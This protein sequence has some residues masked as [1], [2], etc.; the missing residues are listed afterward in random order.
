MSDTIYPQ[1]VQPKG[2]GYKSENIKAYSHYREPIDD[3]PNRLAGNSRIWGD[4]S[5]QVQSRVV[6]ILIE[7]A[8]EKGLSTRET[9][10][11]LAIAR[12]ESGFN[13][14]AA[15]GTT[16]ASGLGQFIDGTGRSYGLGNN[17]FDAQDG[18]RALVD[19]FIDN[20]KLASARGQGE[21]YIYK[22]HHDGPT[23]DYGGLDLAKDKVL[24]FVDK[25][26]KLL[27]QQQLG[28]PLAP[29]QTTGVSAT[30]TQT[31]RTSFDATMQ[32]MMP[33]QAG[34][35][36]HITGSYGEDR[37]SKNHGGVDFNY[38]GG[39]TGRNLQ[40]PV[41]N[42]PVSGKVTFSGGAY[43]TVKI[44]DAQGNSHEILH[45]H[46]RNVK[47]GDTVQAG[48]PIGTMGGRGPDGPNQYAQ[49]VH[50]QLRNPAGSIIDP[51]SFWNGRQITTGGNNP[52]AIDTRTLQEKL[53]A[54]G[55]TGTQGQALQADGIAGS[56]TN[57]AL[58]AFQK[59]HGL[60]VDGIAGPAT[61]GALAGQK[62]LPQQGNAGPAVQS[63][64]EQLNQLG[65]TDGRGRALATDG[66]FGNNTEQ[67][68]EAFQKA[69]GLK[70]DGV[71]GPLTRQALES[72]L[73]KA[74]QQA[75]PAPAASLQDMP[76]FQKLKGCMPDGLSLEKIGQATTCA[77]KAGIDSAEKVQQV[78]VN[79]SM[80][81]VIGTTAGFRASVDL[82]ANP[83]S[84]E[85]SNQQ[86]LALNQEREQQRSQSQAVTLSA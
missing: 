62:S 50:Y 1:M 36:P 74:P 45:L 66:K 42:A 61:L 49:H 14:D 20:R 57:H 28:A 23:R 71:A 21:A 86:L 82:A 4:A 3:A 44:L 8:R 35:K 48:K 9:A 10:H 13:P 76:L 75:T 16:S 54:L 56:H 72:A 15:A 43:G 2:A 24:P 47:E 53:S 73:Q 27:Q 17:R 22:Y 78:H 46:S 37:G 18:A 5:A 64:Q 51:V 40:H 77:I 39:Q 11:V 34:V 59:D 19:H 80:A 7:A 65:F 63:L 81:H 68:L 67:A 25:Y 31:Q 69:N 29:A 38:V 84:L 30:Q 26:E 60:S 55:Y 33:P 70:A 79:G 52:P 12:V 83:P 85:A 41:V 32:Q 58:R 6:D